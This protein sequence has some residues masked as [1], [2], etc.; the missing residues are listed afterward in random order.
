MQQAVANGDITEERID[1]AVSRIL[2]V[3]FELGLFEHPFADPALADTVGSDAHRALAR[4]AVA[5]SQVLLKND[6]QTL[7]LAKATPLILVAGSAADDIG[8]QSGGWT[9]EWQGQTGNIT[10]GTTIRQ[11]IENTV[12][13]DTEVMFNRAGNYRDLTGHG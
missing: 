11:A 9:I 13:A 2:K 12:G 6:D 4:Q 5:K 10:P 1:D 3:K 8:I 7:P